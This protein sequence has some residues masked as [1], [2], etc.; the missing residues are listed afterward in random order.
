MEEDIQEGIE[1]VPLAENTIE[2]AVRTFGDF[3]QQELASSHLDGLGWVVA[4]HSPA[5]VLREYSVRAIVKTTI[6]S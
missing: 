5:N 6:F 2:F 3:F 1:V 4:Q